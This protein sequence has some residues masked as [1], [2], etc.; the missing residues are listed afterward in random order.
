M[1]KTVIGAQWGDEGKGKIIDWLA[2]KSDI[3]IRFQGG[4][5]AGHT[6]V[7]KDKT[8]KLSLLPS[9]IISNKKNIIAD[10]VVVNP[11]ALFKEIEDIEALGIEISP[12]N[13]K[14]SELCT[15][16]LPYHIAL[17]KAREE[18]LGDK[19]IGTTCKGIGPAHEDKVARRAIKIIDLKDTNLLSEKIDEALFHYNVL[20]DHMNYKIFSKNE[21]LEYIEKYKKRL[22]SFVGKTWKDIEL[23]LNEEKNILFEG[24]QAVMLDIDHGTYPYVTSSNTVSAQT[25]I[26]TGIGNPVAGNVIGVIKAYCTRVGSGPFPSEINNEIGELICERGH[27]YGTV[28]GRKRRCGWLDLVALKHA[29]RTG[30]IT[31][32]ALTKIDIL[33]TLENIKICVAYEIDGKITQDFPSCISELEKAKPVYDVITGWNTSTFGQTDIKKLP[34]ELKRDFIAFIEEYFDG[35]PIT[36]LSTGPDRKHTFELGDYSI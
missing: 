1:T 4:N 32:L 21:I 25:S 29:I 14:I 22:L 18:R 36:I 34:L 26:G 28:T 13:L 30:G 24:A 19:K 5:N 23:G 3:V 35:L 12:H 11:E 16:I 17:D 7:N 33:D 31:E 15:L 20:L 9:G 2:E 10:G 8:Y 27:E 6:I